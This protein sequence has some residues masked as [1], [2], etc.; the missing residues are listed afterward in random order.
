MNCFAAS[1]RGRKAAENRFPRGIRHTLQ[2]GLRIIDIGGFGY[3]DP[4]SLASLLK[5]IL[6]GEDGKHQAADAGKHGAANQN[7]QQ[8]HRQWVVRTEYPPLGIH[9]WSQGGF[10]ECRQKAVQGPFGIG[11]AHDVRQNRQ[12]LLILSLL[13]QNLGLIAVSLL[14]AR[15]GSDRRIENSHGS[16]EIVQFEFGITLIGQQ[17]G[18]PG[19][20]CH[21]L[22]EKWQRFSKPTAL[23]GNH[24]QTVQGSPAPGISGN[25]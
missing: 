18:I 16:G 13:D 22:G 5:S 14:I 8:A 6:G 1:P 17:L 21:G 20:Q 15:V 7:Q 10:S 24:P 4:Q 25:R 11:F 12:R 9:L 23:S 19:L 3:C 2:Q